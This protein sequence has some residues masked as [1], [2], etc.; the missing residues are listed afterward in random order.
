MQNIITI[1]RKIEAHEF[2]LFIQAIIG[3]NTSSKSMIDLCCFNAPVTRNLDFAEKVFVD[4]QD[5]IDRPLDGEFYQLDVLSD[6]IIFE[7]QYGVSFAIDAIEHFTNNDAKRLLERMKTISDTQ[8]LF[9][10]M[11]EMWI[12]EGREH[13]PDT[14]KSG[15]VPSD[16]PEYDCIVLKEFH[17]PYDAFIFWRTNSAGNSFDHVK[18]SIERLC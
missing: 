18:K 15:W 14:H 6:N 16:V 9:T 13:C 10:P 12:H 8:V 5:R 4:I 2:Q 7:R 3:D 11:G 17:G 1:E